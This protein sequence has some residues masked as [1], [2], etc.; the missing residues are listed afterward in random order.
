VANPDEVLTNLLSEARA[1]AP[2]DRIGFRDPIAAHGG[3]AIAALAPW[4]SDE[5]LVFFA[6]RAIGAA[7]ANGAREAAVAALRSVPRSMSTSALRDAESELQR[8]G[9][10]GGLG[11]GVNQEVRAFLIAAARE[12][13]FV[14]YSDVAPIAGL[15][16]D[17]PH[18][19]FTVI[20]AL[21]GAIS[22]SEV[23]KGRPMLSSIVIQ[24][25]GGIHLGQGFANLAE[26][27]GHKP[28]GSDPDEFARAE[29]ERTFGYWQ[30][31]PEEM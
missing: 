7:G 31:H 20:G 23:L 4:L 29:A 12:R 5:S 3:A 30:S 13:R 19:R 22:E 8:L 17:N 14:Y 10:T 24:K 1:A 27:L 16:M 21:L 28:L 18:H 26:Q 2:N 6:I 25:G 9:E 15:S 11:A